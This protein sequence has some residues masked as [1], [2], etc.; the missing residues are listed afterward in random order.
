MAFVHGKNTIVLMQGFNMSNYLN[1]VE[2][3]LT[4]D[5]SEITVFNSSTVKS[6][7]GGN[8]DATLSAE[9]LFEGSTA[10]PNVDAF[11]SIVPSSSDVLW[12]IYPNGTTLGSFGN[13][14]ATVHTEYSVT[15]PV[16]DVVS[17]TVSGQSVSG[18]ERIASLKSIASETANTGVGTG[19]DAGVGSSSDASGGVGYL[20][21]LENLRSLTSATIQH[22]NNNSSWDALIS[23]TATTA[24][25]AE[26]IAVTGAVKR[27][28][29]AIFQQ[30]AST[31]NGSFNMGFNRK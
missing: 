9:G 22:S 4:A 10:A 18:R 12:S 27:Y 20:Q 19:F 24:V 3:D 26:R 5:V 15:A 2:T 6:Y 7:I 29:R 11:I 31:L 30:A 13:G 25:T 8:K 28:T 14:I 16:D 23:F 17:M 21:K 1:S